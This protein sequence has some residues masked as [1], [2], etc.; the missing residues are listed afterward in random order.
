MKLKLIYCVL[1]IFFFFSSIA[2]A[3]DSEFWGEGETVWPVEN[4]E[5][6]MVA[7][8]IRVQPGENRWDAECIFVLRN[9]GKE[10]EVQVGFPD[11]T[12][13][14]PEAEP[15]NG[16]IRNFRCYV[17]G[18]EIT[19]EH[20]KGIGNP[21]NP[22]LQ[23]PFA[24]VWKMHFKKGQKRIVKNTYTFGGLHIA[25]GEEVLTYVLKTGALWKDKIQSADIIFD[26]GQRDPGFAS[27]IKPSG[28]LTAGHKLHW[29]FKD[30]EPKDDIEISL[31]PLLQEWYK[32]VDKYAES[33]SIEILKDLLDES[34]WL[35]ER[36]YAHEQMKEFNKKTEILM[37]QLAKFQDVTEYNEMLEERNKAIRMAG[38]SFKCQFELN[39]ME[40]KNDLSSEDHV[41]LLRCMEIVEGVENYALAKT[42]AEFLLKDVQRK[43]SN[44]SVIS[45]SSTRE[46][47]S[48]RLGSLRSQLIEKMQGYDLQLQKSMKKLHK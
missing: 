47:E 15:K 17:D 22:E 46:T 27:S 31:G 39:L 28:Y 44:L 10:M 48:L 9:T 21:L 12:G 32:R 14:E 5:I 42:L 30:F 19:V 29:V 3:D 25:G 4:N 24:Y 6:E 33:G 7:E 20:K 11:Q 34:Q 41:S 8:T 36:K 2:S 37:N 45:D 38:P 13:W 16:T 23:Y 18:R 43:L 26:L 40:K 35:W 1:F